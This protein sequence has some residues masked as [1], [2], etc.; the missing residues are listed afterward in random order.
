MTVSLKER[1]RRPIASMKIGDY[2]LRE[3]SLAGSGGGCPAACGGEWSFA[4]GT[5]RIGR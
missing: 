3:V 5:S 4:S 2:R 1:F